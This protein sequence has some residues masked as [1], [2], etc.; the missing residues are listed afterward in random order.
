MLVL[1]LL[2]RIFICV[3]FLE[4]ASFGRAPRAEA[5]VDLEVELAETGGVLLYDYD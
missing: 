4:L 5:E 1:S 3:V 2:P